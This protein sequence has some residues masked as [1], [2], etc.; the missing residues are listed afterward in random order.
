MTEYQVTGSPNFHPLELL[1]D[2]EDSILPTLLVP[3]DEVLHDLGRVPLQGIP[4][5][6][7]HLETICGDDSGILE[8]LG[9]VVRG[10]GLEVGVV[11]G[12][13][14][15]RGLGNLLDLLGNCLPVSFAELSAIS[16]HI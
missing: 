2:G 10:Y 13:L 16:G 12:D 6:D 7:A 4:S 8:Q 9:R 15:G 5:S 3:S 14:V 1:H 11:P